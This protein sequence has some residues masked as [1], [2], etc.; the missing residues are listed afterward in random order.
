VEPADPRA[1]RSSNPLILKEAAPTWQAGLGPE[2]HIS[3]KPSKSHNYFSKRDRQMKS[4]K[5]YLAMITKSKTR[6]LFN[7]FEHQTYRRIPG[8]HNLYREDSGNT[9]TMTSKHSHVYA[10]SGNSQIYSVNIDGSGHD[11]YSGTEIPK[12]HADFFRSKGYNISADNI[13]ES[14]E[15]SGS[16]AKKYEL[17]ILED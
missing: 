15:L 8:T 5:E 1:A 14:L 10:K 2:A 4:F 11:G 12:A 7:L 3:Q 13:L 6:N 17:V 16:M 9:N